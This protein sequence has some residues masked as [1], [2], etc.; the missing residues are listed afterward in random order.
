M[1]KS[2]IYEYQLKLG[3]IIKFIAQSNDNL[4]NKIFI[5]DYLDNDI[6]KI[7]NDNFER[8]QITINDGKL[9]DESIEEI[10]ILDE[11]IE[12]G[13]AKQHGLNIKTWWSFN[14]GGAVPEV[15]NGEITN[16][17][18][19][20]IEITTYPNKDVIYIDFAYKGIPL[21]LPLKEPIIPFNPPKEI[22]FDDEDEDIK[23]KKDGDDLDNILFD[24]DDD[25]LLYQF[26]NDI[27]KEEKDSLIIK[28]DE[29][30]FGDEKATIFEMTS[31][32]EN[33][34]IYDIETQVNDLLDDLLSTIPSNKRTPFKLK[35][36]N[37]S[38]DRFKQLREEF[39]N[40][41][42]EGIVTSI[43]RNTANYRPLS[44]SLFNLDQPIKWLTP[45]VKN[46]LQLYNINNEDD[47]DFLDISRPI[48]TT[49]QFITE[50]M[51]IFDLYYSDRIPIEQNKYVYLHEQTM[52]PHFNSPIDKLN[53][54]TEKKIKN[55]FE[56]I[57]DNLDD[58][59]SSTATIQQ[60]AKSKNLFNEFDDKWEYNSD[61]LLSR[62]NTTKYTTGL[63]YISFEDI[64]KT[65]RSTIKP[66]TFND[67]ISIQGFL[68]YPMPI[69]NYS[70]LYLQREN[71][72]KKSILHL[73]PYINSY[74]LKNETDGE[75]KYISKYIITEDNDPEDPEFKN[76]NRLNKIIFEEKNL[77]DDR[78]QN[79]TYVEFLNNMIPKTKKLF[80]NIVKY[81]KL[82]DSTS[83][84]KI[85]DYLEPFLIYNKHITFKQYEEICNFVNI[86]C[87]NYLKI[88]IKNIL[89]M[90]DLKNDDNIRSY[91]SKSR[92]SNFFENK[93]ELENMDEKW[94]S[95]DDTFKSLEYIKNIIELDNGRLLHD[96]ITLSDISL[97]QTI[98]IDEKLQEL[99]D[100]IDNDRE[101]YITDRENTCS[102]FTLAK[103][104]KNIDEVVSD[105]KKHEIIF[106]KEYDDTRYDIYNEL[107]HIKAI[108]D[109]KSKKMQ[110]ISHL[111]GD[112]GISAKNA[113]RDADSMIS[114]K[115]TVID[116]D[117]G[118]L[119]LGDY[120]YRYYIR[121]E[122]K[123]HLDEELNDKFIDEI[124][125][126]NV[127]KNCLSINKSCTN[128]EEGKLMIQTE[129]ITDIMSK[130]EDD[131]KL[132]IEVLKENLKDSLARNM[133]NMITLKKYYRTK[134][135]LYDTKKY[136]IADQLE[137]DIQIEVSPYL[138][139]RDA[140]LGQTDIIKK[141][142]DILK[143]TEKYC[144]YKFDEDIENDF[145]KY[146]F[147]CNE[148][149]LILLPTF[150][151]DLALAF[152]NDNYTI[153]LDRICAERGT[154]SDDGD[155]IVDKYSG[156][157]IRYINFESI[158]M[159]EKSGKKNIS[160]EIL[161]LSIDELR[162]A[163]DETILKE[164][165][166][167][168]KTETAKQI[169]NIVQTLDENL[170][171]NTKSYHTTIIRLI[172]NQIDQKLSSVKVYNQK[173]KEAKKLGKKLQSYDKAFNNLVMYFTLSLY[174]IIVQS[175][176]PH[177]IKGKG[178]YGC[179]ET[180]LGFPLEKSEQYG[181]I[182][183]ITCVALK[184][185]YK[186]SDIST[187]WSALPKLT[188]KKSEKYKKN[189]T[190]KITKYIKEIFLNINE[191]KLL[192][193]KKQN[194]LDSNEEVIIEELLS[195][196]WNA[197]LPILEPFEIKKLSDINSSFESSLIKSYK[198]GDNT[199]Y[200]YLN[201]LYGK[202]IYYS[203]SF[204]ATMQKVIDKQPLILKTMGDVHF[205]ENTCCDEFPDKT[206]YE[207]FIEKNDLIDKHNVITNKLT[208]LYNKYSK[209]RTSIFNSLEDTKFYYPKGIDE[210]HE[211]SVYRAVIKYCYFNTGIELDEE[212]KQICSTNISNY[213]QNDSLKAKIK[214]MKSE[215]HTFS[216][217]TLKLLLK[218]INKDNL[219]KVE[220]T[221]KFH[222]KLKFEKMLKYLIEKDVEKDDS[223]KDDSEKDDSE[224]SYCSNIFVKIQE[225]FDRHESHYTEKIDDDVE[226]L[227]FNLK[228]E[229]SI[230]LAN[231][232]KLFK[233][234]KNSRKAIRF[235]ENL[236]D[237]S[238][239]G[240]NIYIKS[241]DETGYF[242]HKFLLSMINDIT[243]IYPSIIL[244][245]VTY[246]I[247]T[248][249]ILKTW[250][251][252]K[253]HSLDIMS[254]ISEKYKDLPKFYGDKN[255]NIILKKLSFKTIDIIELINTIPFLPEFSDNKTICN[256]EMLYLIT[257]FFF[258]CV[259]NTH[260][261]IINDIYEKEAEDRLI[262]G[263]REVLV[264]TVS[265]LLVSYMNTFAKLKK[266]LNKSN[267][268]INEEVLKIKDK[269][270]T[271]IT[272]TYEDLTQEQRKVVKV[273]QNHKLGDWSL[274]ESK[275]IYMYDPNQYDKERDHIEKMA[276]LEKKHG[277]SDEV[278]KLMRDI[279]DM[280]EIFADEQIQQR[281]DEE[282]NN[283]SHL[284][285][286]DD[287]GN[288]DG[289]EFF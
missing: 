245:K 235:L 12:L 70:K 265:S 204:Q 163:E 82:E 196:K 34:K 46:Q 222:P 209:I 22:I 41:N 125:F 253:R 128:K 28:A 185:A 137:D 256:G 50:H 88:T 242:K 79:E 40:F 224:K 152:F 278:T 165:K 59:N 171:I 106:D 81:L 24:D 210:F 113:N 202:I 96:G 276:I 272:T 72:Y 239:R 240:D 23:L 231:I 207:Y 160:H 63:S 184:L 89:D 269:E 280:D 43:K 180:F 220:I 60:K 98:N 139:L 87:D 164:V 217:T 14:F 168:Y 104:F 76:M 110:L 148:T 142:N 195:E 27:I 252:S 80:S 288:M 51:D 134:S 48:S 67:N 263:E 138:D 275:A 31:V 267:F 140:I 201:A 66:L 149:K 47:I 158:D 219:K 174:I 8:F 15:I 255:I 233:N 36:I 266:S 167:E 9:S 55:N 20:C 237:F 56:A 260:Y 7:I 44:E 273:M 232:I 179:K 62:F 159:Y 61:L 116:G 18:E 74:F 97:I 92:L 214:I 45:I 218:I 176:I 247:K 17:E 261:D 32:S 284:P 226:D 146:W 270:K 173:A 277:V 249:H 121:K 227:K 212:L 211:E 77:F 181:I 145:N 221:N 257:K 109:Q 75:D 64:K 228:K 229:N 279:Y 254:K 105:N 170:G 162:K 150:Y 54:I 112:L 206:S 197:F 103:K 29:I 93:D 129:L 83:Y 69:I 86:G 154:I 53:I 286:D 262:R 13:Y 91:S 236:D 132:N 127:Q 10:H 120:E 11:A 144:S 100:S 133:T 123:W 208:N 183:Y 1:Q 42:M 271:Q 215:G 65:K 101:K 126:C 190:D 244:K 166:A 187:P 58:F 143:F 141:Y 189:T 191:I 26:D 117:Y 119:D 122:N 199:M 264:N 136:I 188:K 251:L 178:F 268:E 250:N 182:N 186:D 287:F 282:E 151:K 3:M 131:F 99:K 37:N 274:G 238:D 289:D 2:E 135:L 203:L 246:D 175:S 200:E 147:Y 124:S 95:M 281:I 258:L 248:I 234:T 198:S 157:L 38:I 225:L 33:E 243:K 19:D 156:H 230:M 111:M 39:S 30:K 177:I 213:T 6:I 192:I 169:S 21:N 25:E 259:I 161:D 118:L 108:K 285:E 73:T 68:M 107:G 4:N 35:N 223:E 90:N 172:K 102:V 5:I 71:I 205:L 52:K 283:I 84:Y 16:L 85:I 78:E 216:N 114:G 57:I 241:S 193:K 115:K 155:K 94:Y 153:V 130:I 194:W 49:Q